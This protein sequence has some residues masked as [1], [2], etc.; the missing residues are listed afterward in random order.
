MLSATHNIYK[1]ILITISTRFCVLECVRVRTTILLDLYVLFCFNL[2]IWAFVWVGRL[3]GWLAKRARADVCARI[4]VSVVRCANWMRYAHSPKMGP[5]VFRF[6]CYSIAES[7][8][9]SLVNCP[10]FTLWL[11]FARSLLIIYK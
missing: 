1:Y 4:C 11:S 9:I 2:R 3:V 6:I 7:Y 10:Q 8:G 5:A